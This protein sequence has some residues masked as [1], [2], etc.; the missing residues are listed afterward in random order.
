MNSKQWQD[1]RFLQMGREQER[2]YFIPYDSREAALKGRRED[3]GLFQ[4]LNGTWDF[5]Y[6]PAWYELPEQITHW[7]KLPV[8]SNWQMHGY[9]SP[10]YTNLNYPY[11][12]DIPYVPDQN[13]CGVYRRFFTVEQQEKELYLMFEGVNA[14]FYLYINGAEVGYSQGS[15]CMSEFRI[16]PYLHP[17]ENEIRVAVL[18]WCDGSYLEDQ[19]FLR[20][21]GIFR[22]VYLLYRSKNHLQDMEIHTG[23]TELTARMRFCAGEGEATVSLLDGEKCLMQQTVKD[24][25]VRFTLP[26]ARPWSSESPNLYTL[27]VACGG[28][29]IPFPVGFRTIGVS[30]RGELLI[31]GKSVKLKGV[32]HHDTHPTKGHVLDAED[33]ERDLY[34][35]KRLN[36]NT[37]RTSHYPPAPEFLRLCDKL[38]FYVVDEADLEMHGFT[39]KDTGCCYHT[40]DPQWPTDH[41]D[42]GEALMER[43][44]RMVER[45][46]NSPCV[47][48][49]SLGNE[50]G[51]G[52]HFDTMAK[53]AKSRDPERLV[54][55]ERAWQANNPPWFDVISSMYVSVPDL[56][57]EGSSQDK[58]PYF[59]C[60]YAH[61]MGNG[62]GDLWDYQQLFDRYPRLIGGCIWEWADHA[63]CRDGKYYYGGDFGE[64]THDRNFCVDGLVSAQRTLK[65]GS[66]EAK[67]AY[68]PLYAELAPASGEHPL[69]RLTNRFGFTNLKEYELRWSVELDGLAVRQGSLTLDLAPGAS[70]LWQVPVPP[71]EQCRL[72]RYL[73]LSLVRKAPCAWA[74]AGYEIAMC[75]LPLAFTPV[76][77]TEPCREEAW[78]VSEADNKIHIRNPAGDGY[79]FHKIRGTLCGIWKKGRNLLLDHMHLTLWRA[80]TDNDRHIKNKWGLFEDNCAGWNLNRLFDKCYAVAWEQNGD[81]VTV[82]VSGSLAGI[83]REPVVR[84][85]ARYRVDRGGVLHVAVDGDVNEKTVWLPRFG[86][87]MTLPHSMEELEYYGM[88]PY[89]NYRD[90]CHHVK[91]GRYA[92][93]VTGEYVPYVKP[94]EHGNHTAVRCLRI[95]DRQT[96]RTLRVRADGALEFQA[97]H[98][99]ARE[100]T[101]KKHHFELEQGETYLRLDYRVSGIGSNSC[102]PELLEKYRLSEKKLRFGFSLELL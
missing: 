18:K 10:C 12:V 30:D 90:M 98:Y 2:A 44:R 6:F 102:G 39:T 80:P 93:T 96:G 31:N 54:H 71:E 65:A 91:M 61:A 38:G 8:P 20:L 51:Y 63:V 79:T 53:W 59:L 85:Q 22:D 84:Y 83:A 78:Q 46:K 81:G 66:L 48:M 62:P 76:A 9:D 60:E 100:L 67:A 13:P 89:E 88:G 56:E 41:P 32:N 75:Q 35:M 72:G 34:L 64:L 43:L 11:P 69:V 58:R 33:M 27:L 57:K 55:Y 70:C 36:I 37:I 26:D 49:W 73:N 19:D 3:S 23:L 15:H 77:Q 47:I 28:E 94:Q 68:Q 14:C 92:S 97:S 74:E 24:G 82:A 25:C 86:F 17:G 4:L 21:S 16:T 42:W 1:P 40:Y 99:T 87:E 50:S 5:A 7:D 95:S 29:Y 101:E 45:D 52:A